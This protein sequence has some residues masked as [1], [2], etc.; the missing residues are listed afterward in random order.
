MRLILILVLVSGSGRTCV[1][2]MLR[3]LGGL[4]RLLMR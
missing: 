4:N 3:Y 1:A 2:D